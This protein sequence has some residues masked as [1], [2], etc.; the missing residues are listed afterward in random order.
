MANLVFFTLGFLQVHHLHDVVEHFVQERVLHRVVGLNPRKAN[1]L[2]FRV[3][4][5]NR[6]CAC[7][8]GV[9]HK[10]HREGEAQDLQPFRS[11]TS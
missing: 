7:H 4:E 2:G 9:V 5:A 3:A 11:S 1:R 10:Q 6:T 8:L